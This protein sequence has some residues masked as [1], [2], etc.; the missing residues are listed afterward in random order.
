MKKIFSIILCAAVIL[1]TGC[2]GVSQNEYNSVFEEKTSLKYDNEKLQSE[3]A[4]LQGKNA[5][6]QS[7]LDTLKSENGILQQKFDEE[8]EKHSAQDYC[9][10]ISNWMLGRPQASVMKNETSKYDENVDLETTYYFEGSELTAKLVYTIKDTVSTVKAAIYISAYEKAANDGMA[11]LMGDLLN[12][13]VIIYRHSSGD[14][15]KTTYWYKDDNNVIQRY[16][17]F[18]LYGQKQ[19]IAAECDRLAN[20]S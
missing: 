14:V 12:E 2:S 9:A 4:N 1:M 19:G 10:D 6:L 3:I 17:F 18:T 5:D 7:E 16:G 8:V 15:I 13:F 20:Q 11:D